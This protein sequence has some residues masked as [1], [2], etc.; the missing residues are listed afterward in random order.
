MNDSKIMFFTDDDHDDLHLMQEII[1]SLGHKAE[2]FHD[3]IEMLSTLQNTPV[4]PD[5][6]F[7]DITMP[8][9]D[10][11]EILEKLRASDPAFKDIP[12]II[13]SGNCDEQC[14]ARC[15]EL[16]ANYYITKAFSYNGLKAALEHAVGINWKTFKPT[17]EDFL[18]EH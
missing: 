18:F 2:L 17:R 7:L 8:R 5:I 11:F 15:F 6:I 10:G 1:T 3:G 16:G 12:V 9:T 14:I 4:K 13:H